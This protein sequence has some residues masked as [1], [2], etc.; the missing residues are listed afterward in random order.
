MNGWILFQLLI[1]IALFAVVILYIVRESRAPLDEEPAA[2]VE[3]ENINPEQIESL[4]D[5]LARLVVRAE[6]A[7][8]RIEKG[9]ATA[10]LA[11][12]PKTPVNPASPPGRPAASGKAPGGRTAATGSEDDV[13]VQAA[14]LIKKGL[15]DEEISRIVGL[16]AHEVSLI[17][18]M[19]T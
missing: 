12:P 7:A 5:E 14:R 1:D 3:R 18:E 13:Y 4:L 16:P 6:K 9:L 17:R 2:A 19:A 11:E 15:P 10:G 8:D